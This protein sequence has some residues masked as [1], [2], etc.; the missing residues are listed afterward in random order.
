[1]FSE[2]PR[3]PR[4][5]FLQRAGVVSSAFA[6]SPFL[7]SCRESDDEGNFPQR[8]FVPETVRWI[9]EEEGRETDYFFVRTKP[10]DNRLFWLTLEER[11]AKVAVLDDKGYSLIF[12]GDTC[13]L[14]EESWIKRYLLFSLPRETC[15]KLFP[16]V[17]GAILAKAQEE[18]PKIAN[19]DVSVFRDRALVSS[20]GSAV[21]LSR[22]KQYPASPFIKNF[23]NG[24]EAVREIPEEFIDQIPQSKN[25]LDFNAG[26]ILVG[27]D[28]SRW[29]LQ[30]G[31]RYKIDETIPDFVQ[32]RHKSTR[33][34]QLP[35]P[36]I[37]RIPQKEIKDRFVQDQYG[38][39]IDTRSPR[40]L[41]FIAG[42]RS[43]S[44]SV[45]ETFGDIALG[46]KKIGWR[47]EQIVYGT[48]DLR[49]EGAIDRRNFV[50][51]LYDEGHSTQWTPDS[52]DA[53]RHNFSWLKSV[54]PMSQIVVCGHSQ[55]GD[56]GFHA[57]LTHPDFVCKVITIDSPLKGVDQAFL[58]VGDAIDLDTIGNL[59]GARA[60][61]FYIGIG[62]NPDYGEQIE[63]S[64]LGLRRRGVEVFTFTSVGDR[65]VRRN[66]AVLKNSIRQIGDYNVQ[67]L[68]N[69]PTNPYFPLEAHGI[70]LR[71]SPFVTELG[72][73]V[74]RL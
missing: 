3:F 63:Q 74:G 44:D 46:A 8:I 34:F 56:L 21:F 55:G 1:M 60:A 72:K 47:E 38:R 28:G 25:K 10:P 5:D 70:L 20:N 16:F 41:F 39:L 26:E 17:R 23:F 61:D 67:L 68:W 69:V 50:P 42:F 65:L 58:D 27:L 57:A 11:N 36:F 49:A 33:V 59:L 51:L 2:L 29:Y 4:R 43:T 22:G 6:L 40:L 37:D 48:Y 13:Q 12:S 19:A 32:R 64:A 54:A 15:E 24:G 45:F 30:N 53:M 18:A 62:D 7:L 31:A 66:M 35:R 73:L 71:H 14:L 9:P 52:Q